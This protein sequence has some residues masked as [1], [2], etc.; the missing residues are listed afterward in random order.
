M[1]DL[2]GTE[3]VVFLM[4]RLISSTMIVLCGVGRV[5]VKIAARMVPRC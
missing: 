5:S 4:Y 3:I 1:S 2:V